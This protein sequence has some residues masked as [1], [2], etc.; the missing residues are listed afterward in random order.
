MYIDDGL[1]CPAGYR[2]AGDVGGT[3][4][5]VGKSPSTKQ[6]EEAFLRN[7]AAL[8]RMRQSNDALAQRNAVVAENNRRADCVMLRNQLRQSDFSMRQ[9]SAWDNMRQLRNDRQAILDQ[10]VALGC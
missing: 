10:Q 8:E 6:Q 3:L 2:T 7:R 4:S 5:V 9:G 1:S